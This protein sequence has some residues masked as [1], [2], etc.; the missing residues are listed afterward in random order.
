VKEFN[1]VPFSQSTQ[2]DQLK[3]GNAFYDVGFKE[4]PLFIR[5]ATG[6]KAIAESLIQSGESP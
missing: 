5:R 6:N 2:T 1:K 4:L 3:R